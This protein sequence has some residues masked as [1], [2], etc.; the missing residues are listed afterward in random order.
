MRPTACDRTRMGFIETS[1]HGRIRLRLADSYAWRDEWAALC[2][3]LGAESA[4]G[5]CVGAEPGGCVTIDVNGSRG[6]DLR[7][8]REIFDDVYITPTGVIDLRYGVE[9]TWRGPDRLVLNCARPALEWAM[10]SFLLAGLRA[11][12]VFF[13]GAALEKDGAAWAFPSWGGVGKTALVATMVR[14]HGWRVLGDDFAILGEAGRCYAFPKPMVLYP[15]HRA[16]FPELFAAGRGPAAPVAM[17]EALTRAALRLKPVLRKMPGLLQ[18]AR[19]NNPQSVRLLPSDVFGRDKLAASADLAGVAFLERVVGLTEPQLDEAPGG[20]A[21]RIVGTTLSE[22]D[23]RTMMVCNIALGSGH[24]GLDHFYAPW[25]RLQESALRG[26]PQYVFRIPAHWPV[27]RL[28][29]SV[30]DRLGARMEP[31]AT[32]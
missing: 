7:S 6:M 5:D 1:I 32:V 23:Q 22:F 28:V 15:Y 8:A 25:V 26:K 19:R 12:C 9:V 29:E 2:A 4:A 21:G 27:E 14:R 30:L 24:L 18:W 20:L 16:M 11:G 13:H 10:P 17:N 3:D 31:K